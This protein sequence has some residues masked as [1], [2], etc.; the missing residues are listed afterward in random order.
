MG[1]T[2][3][4]SLGLHQRL[5]TAPPNQGAAVLI[6]FHTWHRGTKRLLEIDDSNPRRRAQPQPS[7][8]PQRFS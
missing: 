3:G 2:L 5:L 8:V 4:S 7:S 1:E 6:H